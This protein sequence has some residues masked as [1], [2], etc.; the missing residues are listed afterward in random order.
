LK[1]NADVFSV[2]IRAGIYLHLPFLYPA[3]LL[4][5][6]IQMR[7]NRSPSCWENTCA[8]WGRG[9]ARQTSGLH[10]DRVF[11]FKS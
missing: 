3:L 5:G 6:Y 4:P 8:R 7:S 10:K 1:Q 2:E 9:R 11:L